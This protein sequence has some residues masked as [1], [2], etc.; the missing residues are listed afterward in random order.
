[1][2]CPRVTESRA[3]C[4]WSVWCTIVDRM[5]DATDAEL[6]VA[7]TERRPDAYRVAWERFSPLVLGVLRRGLGG[8]ELDDAR[9]EVFS[10]LFRR[11]DTLR[12]PQSLRPFVIAITFNIIKYER[13]RR[14]RRGRVALRPDPAQVSLA[15]DGRQAPASYALIRFTRLLRK[16]AA[17]ERATFVFR[18]IEGMTVP[19]V[20]EALNISE[21]TAR[22][23]FD[24]A[25][26]YLH[27]WAARDPFLNEYLEEQRFAAAP[28]KF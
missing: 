23:S 21:P 1:M 8:D 7:L 5:H 9:Q 12:E 18:F 17:R 25:W 2:R 3:R 6:A 14:R 22:R 13:R 16:L 10:C 20:A 24:R 19:Q 15:D 26:S 11:V 28:E 4:H 27:K